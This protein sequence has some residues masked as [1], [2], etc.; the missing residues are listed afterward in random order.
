M[1]DPLILVLLL[2]FLSQLGH[3]GKERTVF[4]SQL[5][6]MLLSSFLTLLM[7]PIHK[8]QKKDLIICVTHVIIK[9]L[10]LPVN[11]IIRR[12]IVSN[13]VDDC[14]LQGKKTKINVLAEV[15][16]SKSLKVIPMKPMK[17]LV[18]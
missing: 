10:T 7:S 4:C 14:V 8:T 11:S 5:D 12:L 16:R 3:K 9:F 2:L 13:N 1:V 15:E 18:G 17:V 6:I